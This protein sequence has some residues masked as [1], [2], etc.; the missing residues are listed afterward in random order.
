MWKL[1]IVRSIAINSE[2]Q[3]DALMYN[4]VCVYKVQGELV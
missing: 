2:T 3:Y 1:N 4:C